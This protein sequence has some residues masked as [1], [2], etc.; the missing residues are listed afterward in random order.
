M[1]EKNILH[2]KTVYK[3]HE[4]CIQCIRP[5]CFSS[6]LQREMQLSSEHKIKFILKKIPGENHPPM[7]IHSNYFLLSRLLYMIKRRK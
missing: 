6:R 2:I 5:V 7:K 3:Q 4:K 1:R